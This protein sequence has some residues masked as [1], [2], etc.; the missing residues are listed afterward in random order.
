RVRLFA[1]PGGWAGGADRALQ[2]IADGF[3][4]ALFRRDAEHFLGGTERWNRQRE[5]VLRHGPQIRKMPFPDL[6]LAAGLIQL[7]KLDEI[8]IVEFR[9]GWII[10]R[11]MSILPDAKTAEINRLPL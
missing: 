4:F 9:H 5:C 8:W 11:Q 2:G 6:L 7:H 3:G 1:E 10:E